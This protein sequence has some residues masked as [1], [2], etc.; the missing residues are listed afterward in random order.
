MPIQRIFLIKGDAYMEK[1]PKHIDR[2]RKTFAEK[3]N[4]TLDIPPDV[5]P[6]GTL[7]AIRGR[8]SLSLSGSSTIL[9]YTPEQIKLAIHKNI[10]SIK[11]ARLV[12]TSY[13]A[14]EVVIE[15]RIDSVSFEEA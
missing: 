1:S 2:T 14:S 11:G 15:G 13:H 3:L 8:A 5:L 6:H 12:C 9:L 7:V 10:L 4:K